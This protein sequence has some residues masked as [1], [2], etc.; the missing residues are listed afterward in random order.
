MK[1]QQKWKNNSNIMVFRHILLSSHNTK[2]VNKNK[3]NIDILNTANN[4]TSRSNSSWMTMQEISQS[5]S[6]KTPSTLTQKTEPSV[7]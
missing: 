1:N 7:L 5:H 2:E 6:I 3:R 4:K